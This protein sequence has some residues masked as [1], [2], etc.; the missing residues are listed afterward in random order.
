MKRNPRIIL[1]IVLAVAAIGFI[2]WY[3][4]LRPTGTAAAGALT[5]SGTVETTEINIAPETA[6]KIL[7]VNVREGDVVKSGDVLVQLDNSILTDQRAIAQVNLETAQLALLQLTSPTIL[8][9]AQ[10]A[11]AQDQIDLDNAQT[12]LN[13]QLYFSRNTGAIQNA[14][15]SLTLAADKLSKAQDA[16]NNLGG[17]VE[18]STVKAKAYQQLYAA[19]QNY[20]NALFVY[21]TWSGK[22]NQEQI[23]LKTAAVA[24]LT[25]KLAEDQALVTDLTGG[26]V[27]DNATG[28]ALAQIEQA[29]LNIRMAQAN[30]NLLDDQI[31]KTTVVAPV[32]GVVMAR[33]AEPGSVVNAGAALFT[34][35]RL[36]ELTITVYVPEDRLGEVKLGETASVSV[37]SFPGV[38]FNATVSY[39]SD[40]AE[41]T[42]RNVQTVS[43]RKNT[44]FAVKL[45]LSDI[46]GRLKPGMP[47]DV[48]FNAK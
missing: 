11:A 10:R 23:N 28:A 36:D 38:V 48:V 26:Q 46:T 21:N 29:R 4:F 12:S 13:N 30:L 2:A 24:L 42:P 35:G 43:G 25:A 9:N 5:A 39:I 16:Y 37:D 6:G 20:N 1:P 45:S 47:A 3:F 18:T 33:N 41:F 32:D 8:A 15:A 34:L 14:L 31:K 40:Q 22:N 17:E 44:V 19:Q 7:Q 27:P